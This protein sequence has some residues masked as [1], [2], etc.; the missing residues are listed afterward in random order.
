[1]STPSSSEGK[2]DRKMIVTSS[3]EKSF[4]VLKNSFREYYF[5]STKVVEEP[6]KIEKREFGYTHFGQPGMVRH[7]TFR[8][9]G[10]LAAV[11][12]REAPSDVYCS[13][14]YYRFPA[15][16][17]QEKGWQGSDLIFDI[18]GKDLE[19][20]CVSSH[21]YFCCTNCGLPAPTEDTKQYTCRS[22][23]GKKADIVS[24]PCSN[25]VEESKKEVRK[26]IGFLTEDLGMD[27]GGISLYFS[28]NNGFHVHVTDDAF[29]PLDP[30]AR[31]DLVGY[32]SG[33]G[34]LTDNVGVRKGK[35]EN[36][37][38][39]K[40]PKGGISYG[41]R[42]KIGEKLRVES[43]SMIRL[44]HIVDNAGGYLPFKLALEKMAKQ[45]GVRID[46]QV[47]TDVHRIFRMPGT[48]NSKSGLTKA[49]CKDFD[50]FDPFVDAC[51][52]GDRKI[53]I[54]VKAPVK[55]RL[56]GKTFNLSK[57][58]AELPAY[59]AVY[60]ICKGLAEAS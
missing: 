46:P 41:W 3:Q 31:S 8:S 48:L 16:P 43:S 54:R 32:I 49:K 7:L 39:V 33:V 35:A 58:S 14:A 53:S 29:V 57:E 23:G 22:C 6:A 38:T 12:V 50:S 52:L 55:A 42:K 25:C 2:G 10:E 20:A 56:R 37:F 15:Q 27:Q 30:A 1:M 24:V 28:G 17:M 26:L 34:F 44:R 18:D 45:M 13:N 11:L 36:L 60:L 19:L 59:A 47:S 5:K 4:A 40:F 51:L 9:I 21:S